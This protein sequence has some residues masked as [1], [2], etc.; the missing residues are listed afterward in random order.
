MARLGPRD[1]AYGRHQLECSQISV[2]AGIYLGFDR[3]LLFCENEEEVE[4]FAV[5]G[6]ELSLIVRDHPV[7]V[8]SALDDGFVDIAGNAPFAPGMENL[9]AKLKQRVAL[10]LHGGFGTIV[11]AIDTMLRATA[12]SNL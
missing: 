4:Q 12:G 6:L 7:R 11:E 1:D 8:F 10:I 3:R 9:L 2:V 5:A